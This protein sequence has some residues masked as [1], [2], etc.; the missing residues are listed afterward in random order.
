MTV[1]KIEALTLMVRAVTWIILLLLFSAWL[2][3]PMPFDSTD[4]PPHRSGMSVK[5]DCATGLQYLSAGRGLIPRMTVSGD[6]MT[7]ICVGV[8]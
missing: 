6:H 3:W 2:F 4:N 5:T 8:K 7:G 1:E